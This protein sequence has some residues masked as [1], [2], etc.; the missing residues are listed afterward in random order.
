MYKVIEVADMLGISKVTI[1][2]KIELL[3]KDLKSHIHKKKNITYLDD[4]AV[5]IIKENTPVGN[6]IPLNEEYSNLK[7]EYEKSL[8]EIDCLKDKKVEYLKSKV[9]ELENEIEL[10]KKQIEMKNE[11]IKLL[12]EISKSSKARIDKIDSHLKDLNKLML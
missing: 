6:K 5:K 9:S 2:K 3:K 1:Y 12:K 8:K 11:Q 4:E 7:D 10:K